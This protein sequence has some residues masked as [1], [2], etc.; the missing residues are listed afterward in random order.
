[1]TLCVPC[2]FGL[3]GLA[4]DELRYLGMK[5]V[6]SETGRVLFEGD[7]RDLVRASLW[8]RTGERVYVLLGEFPAP[9]FDAL[10]EGVKA[11][12]W[13]DFIP[14]NARFPVKCSSLDSALRSLP[15][16]QRIVKKAAA[17]RLGRVYGLERLPETGETVSIRCS[18]LK[19]RA[20][21]YLDTSGA[22][23]HKRGWRANSNEA[24]LR[25][26]LAAAMVKLSR[27]KGRE[28]FLDPFCGSGTIAIE[29][30]LAALNRAPGLGRRFAAERWKSIP[31]ALWG[32]ER[33]AAREKEYRGDYRIF[34]SDIDPKALETARENARK[35]GVTEYITFS[36]AD[37]RRLTLPEEKGVLITNPP[38]GD[39]LMD[40]REAELLVRAVGKS[41][42]GSR[43]W[44]IYI[45]TS[46]LDFEKN[47]GRRASKRRKLYN[48]MIQCQLYMYF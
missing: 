17:D 10:F 36:Q 26:T 4:A 2:L 20:S 30:A 5:E 13:E 9:S 16:C 8:L 47:F 38:Y 18:L 44:R 43:D 48:G 35:A 1:V 28:T 15:D 41:W 19:D 23:L 12:P 29:A 24:P 32:E 42:R 39:R 40:I 3:E 21:L 11:L 34:A 45:L 33:A 25:E 27:F 46:D 14:R 31:E 22:S 6:R 7:G 37:A